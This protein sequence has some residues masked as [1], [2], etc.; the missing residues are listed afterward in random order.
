[1]DKNV[2]KSWENFLNPEILRSNLIIGS[3]Y[4]TAFEILKDC[5]IDRLR[6]FYSVGFNQD[7]PIIGNDYE[8]KVLSKHNNPL[9]ASLYWLRDLSIISDEDI[10][11]FKLIKNRRNKLA[12]EMIGFLNKPIALEIIDDLKG[13]IELLHKIEIWWIKEVEIPTDPDL[14]SAD[15]N[16]DKIIPGSIM[17][18][19]LMLDIALGSKEESEYYFNEFSKR[20]K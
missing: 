11:G 6:D 10:D 4:I 9:F 14:I 15:L 18:L 7:G 12:H 17:T 2:K 3:L 5:I 20:M 19:R 16:Y 1:M 8:T 13:I